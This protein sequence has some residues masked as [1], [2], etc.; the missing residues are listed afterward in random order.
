MAMPAQSQLVA[1]GQMLLAAHTQSTGLDNS[2]RSGASPAW[3]EV[4]LGVTV[5]SL[6]ELRYWVPCLCVDI[7]RF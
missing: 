7:L 3:K 2:S 5:L 1:S 4:V 6:S